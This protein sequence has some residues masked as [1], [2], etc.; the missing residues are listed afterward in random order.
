MTPWLGRFHREIINNNSG[1][2]LYLD[3]TF[4]SHE[5]KSLERALPMLTMPMSN[6]IH[7]NM[8]VDTQE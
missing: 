1:T 7:L 3:L 4:P 6:L 5:R 2:N 8:R